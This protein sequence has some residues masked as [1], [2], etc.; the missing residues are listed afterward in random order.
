M[1]FISETLTD[2]LDPCPANSSLWFDF[3]DC[4]PDGEADTDPALG[5]ER[6]ETVRR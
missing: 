5:V 1:N 4:F 6:V 3:H 2:G